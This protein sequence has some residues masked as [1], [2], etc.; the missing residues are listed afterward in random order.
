MRLRRLAIFALL[1]ALP[2]RA[3]AHLV[4][5]GVGPFYDGIAHLFVSPIDLVSTV[6]VALLAGLTGRRAGKATA[7]TMPTAWLA[8]IVFASSGVAAPP[9]WGGLVGILVVGSLVAAL[10]A[11]ASAIPAGLAG[12]I[13][14]MIGW[15]NGSA[16][17]DTGTDWLAA[18]GIVTAVAC[19]MLLVAAF[20]FTRPDNWQRVVMRVLGS[21]SAAFALLALAFQFRPLD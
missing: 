17:L 13:G 20:A 9:M 16:M 1:I 14:L 2:G 6:A 10:P 7:L 3:E 11:M 8:G 12:L 19:V 21:W 5:S 15:Q 18:L 4:S